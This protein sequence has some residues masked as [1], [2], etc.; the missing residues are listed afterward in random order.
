MTNNT[1][2]LYEGLR[3]TLIEAEHILT[4]K[5]L[6][7]FQCEK[8]GD[9]YDPVDEEKLYKFRPVND[10]IK[11]MMNSKIED[12][13]DDVREFKKKVREAVANY[14]VSEGC[15]CCQDYDQ[16]KVHRQVLGELLDVEPQKSSYDDEPYYNFYQYKS[17]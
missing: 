12:A 15:S 9:L 10:D 1:F 17:K 3:G 11:H 13:L 7:V 8:T 16:H 6:A 5:V 2:E 4:G 14:M